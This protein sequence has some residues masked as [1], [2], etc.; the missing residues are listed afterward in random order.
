MCLRAQRTGQGAGRRSRALRGAA[1]EG[2]QLAG[3]CRPALCVGAVGGQLWKEHLAQHLDQQRGAMW[4]QRDERL[5]CLGPPLGGWCGGGSAGAM[6]TITGPSAQEKITADRHALVSTAGV[7]GRRV[8][9]EGSALPRRAKR[10]QATRGAR[11]QA[12]GDLACG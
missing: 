11:P 4:G 9:R 2:E 1:A 7:V 12:A 10:A 8:L 3:L 5:S 6:S